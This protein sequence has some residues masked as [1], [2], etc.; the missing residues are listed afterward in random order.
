MDRPCRHKK[1]MFYEDLPRV[2]PLG[3]KEKGV[4]RAYAIPCHCQT[5]F[6]IQKS[7]RPYQEA[8]AMG[9]ASQKSVKRSGGGY[10]RLSTDRETKGPGSWNEDGY[11]RLSSHS[12][13]RTTRL[14]LAR[15]QR[16]PS[17]LARRLPRASCSAG[18]C[19]AGS[20][21]GAR[22]AAST[23]LQWAAK[24]RR[25]RQEERQVPGSCLRLIGYEEAAW[26]WLL[27]D[28]G[29]SRWRAGKQTRGARWAPDAPGFT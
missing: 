1:I 25:A 19:G 9:R 24:G 27:L 15:S 21:D 8:P 3:L 10:L 7:R 11:L 6:G 12:T 13:A 26:H 2:A 22:T 18:C 20:R 4:W 28:T 29:A 23:P 17:F 14:I 16:W 5:L